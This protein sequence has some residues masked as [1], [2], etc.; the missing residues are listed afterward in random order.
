M[1]IIREFKQITTAA[2]TTAAVIK[3]AWEDEISVVS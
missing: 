3:K 1:T 2:A